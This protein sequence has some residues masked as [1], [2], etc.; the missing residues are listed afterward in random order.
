M[1]NDCLRSDHIVLHD[2]KGY[3]RHDTSGG[4][5]NNTPTPLFVKELGD[6]SR[7]S[8]LDGFAHGTSGAYSHE[9]GGEDR[10]SVV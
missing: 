10:K 6:R 9:E 2:V 7:K 1:G 3:S 8:I 4:E 5:P